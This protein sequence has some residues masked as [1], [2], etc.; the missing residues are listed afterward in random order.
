M[1]TLPTGIQHFRRLRAKNALYVDKTEL[2]HRLINTGDFV[3]LARPR[4]FGK[5]L[6]V[7]LLKELFEGH[8]TF[9]KGL[10]IEDKIG[11]QPHTNKFIQLLSQFR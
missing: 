9:F 1:Q 8:Q 4:R 7:T 3:F 11:W 2:V 10:W 6:L 5:S